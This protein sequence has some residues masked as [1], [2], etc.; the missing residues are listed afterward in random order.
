L[1][2]RYVRT[3]TRF[4]KGF[5]WKDYYR[6]LYAEETGDILGNREAL[7]EL[8]GLCRINNIKLLIVNIPELRELN[9]YSFHYATEYIRTLAEDEKVPFLDLLPELAVHEP[10]SLWVSPEDPHAGSKANS[11][12]ASAV[13]RKLIAEGLLL[14]QE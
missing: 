2:D 3:K 14:E 1:F 8:V 11:I 5:N 7:I 12:I 6:E 13:Y 10:E 9:D 4:I